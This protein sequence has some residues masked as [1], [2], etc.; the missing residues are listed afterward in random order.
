ML[1]R[2][3]ATRSR[4]VSLGLDRV[5]LA[6]ERLGSPEGRLRAVQIAGTNGKGSTAAMTEAVL[7]AAGLRTGLYTSPH[8]VRFTERI[9][10]DGREADGETL[11]ALFPRVEATAVPLTYFEA[12]TLLAFLAMAEAGVELAVLETGL[13]GRLDAVT[14]CHPVACA[15]T[16]VGLD[17]TDLLGSTLAEIA[18][19]KAG[20]AKPG[21]PLFLGPLPVEADREI[22]RV[23]A[24]VGAPLR[25]HGI[26]FGPAP[27][28]PALTGPHQQV[29][30]AIAVALAAAAVGRPLSNQAIT[31]GLGSVKWPG[32]LEQVVPS[33]W[34]DCAHNEEGARALAAALPPGVRTLVCS[35]V[36]GKDARAIVAVLAP[37][38]ERVIVTRA[39]NERAQ[40]PA[41]LAALVPGVPTEIAPD[42]VA[43][44]ARARSFPGDV[45][46]AGSIFLVGELRAHLRGEP[47]DPVGADP[48][49]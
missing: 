15:I 32:R 4:G 22:A 40:D 8:L 14:T 1:A 9:R 16:T 6:L 44:L 25:R 13:G 37:H 38:F 43:A 29:N 46:V 19:E 49:P 18:R 3:E 28:A 31:A 35:I 47:L 2:L 17:H 45:V 36:R 39:R 34:L 21:V 42:P 12:A 30:A 23:A 27:V 10:I 24:R 7:R 26:D 41:A 48:L 5:R 33:V 11:A 20:I